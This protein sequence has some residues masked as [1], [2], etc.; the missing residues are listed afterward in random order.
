MLNQLLET[1]IQI[2]TS[3]VSKFDSHAQHVEDKLDSLD[4]TASD[5]KTN[6]E[7]IFDIK[8][9]TGAVITPVQNIK[10]NTD[11]IATSSQTSANNT[12]AILNNVSTLSTNTGKAAAFAEDCA[13]NTLEIKD[14]ITTIASDTTQLRA[15]SANIAADVSSINQAIGYYVANTLVTED[16]EGALCSF[17]TDLE[18]YLQKAVV[19]IPADLTGFSGITLTKTGKNLIKLNSSGV[20]NSQR[21]TANYTDSGCNFVV[22]GTYSRIMYKIKVNPGTVYT[23][24]FIG[25]A[26]AE[27][28]RVIFA[29]IQSWDSPAY[30][31]ISMNTELTSYNRTFTANSEY[32]YIGFY[33]S[34]TTTT[35]DMD[36]SN[37]ILSC[38]STVENYEPYKSMTY[39]VSFGTTITDGA[40]IDLLEGLIKINSTPVSYQSITP[41]AVRTYKGVN[42]IYSDV[43]TTALTYRETLKKYLEKH[44]Q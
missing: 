3:W 1:I 42:N 10:A 31:Y 23:I 44:N 20:V 41:V 16:S 34:G 21:I 36:I 7:P 14:K 19:T 12:T 40:E 35:G 13:N 4:Q 32:L 18:D 2:L 25:E 5:I 9:N 39:P 37:L 15:D 33:L 8:N 17:D 6:T 26:T 43:G 29:N 27:Y 38:G 22:G 11:S 24:S 30:G 28:R